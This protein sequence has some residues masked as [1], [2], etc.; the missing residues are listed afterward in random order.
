MPELTTEFDRMRAPSIRKH[1]PELVTL[2]V[3]PKESAD[4]PS[5]DFTRSAPV[6]MLSIENTYRRRSAELTFASA[7]LE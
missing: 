2:I 1:N 5:K 7:E 3:P 6:P 4:G